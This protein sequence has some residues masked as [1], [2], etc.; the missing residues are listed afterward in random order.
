MKLRHYSHKPLALS[1]L[2]IREQD[3][4]FALKPC[5][6]WLSDDACES[7]WRSWCNAEGFGLARLTYVHDVKLNAKANVLILRTAKDIDEFTRKWKR[8]DDDPP[9]M[10]LFH[11]MH[12]PWS[13]I[14]E[15]Y[16]GL[17]ITPYVW[18]R[19]LSDHCMWYY[20]WDCASGCIWHPTAIRSITLR[21][22]PTTL[23]D[24]DFP[25]H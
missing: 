1:D 24:V 5:G 17:I 9:E 2:K 25:Q 18:Q 11:T 10:R 4:R 21:V 14:R 3:D 22:H 12:F 23:A 19:R 16:D 15:E 8:V 13:A 20:G 7:N 6:L